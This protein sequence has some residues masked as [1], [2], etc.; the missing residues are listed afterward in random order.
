MT[1]DEFSK[2]KKQTTWSINPQTSAVLVIDMLND[3]L[4]EGGKMV[5]PG[6]DH[7]V[8]IIC[9]TIR[10]IRPEREGKNISD[11][12]RLAASVSRYRRLGA[13]F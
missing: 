10:R 11:L 2:I 1:I 5:L 4:V 12:S 7:I 3:F 8:S 6:G 9:Q 13:F